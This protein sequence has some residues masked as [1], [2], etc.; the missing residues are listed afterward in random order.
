LRGRPEA[1]Q[2]CAPPGPG[3]PRQQ[4]V[5][6]ASDGPLR[7]G[8]RAAPDARFAVTMRIPSAPRFAGYT[9]DLPHRAPTARISSHE[10]VT[11]SVPLSRRH[12]LG[13][14]GAAGGSAA[15]YR[16]ALVLG[17]A[18]MVA[19]AAQPDIAPLRPG[20]RRKVVILGAGIS[21]LTAA[22]ELSRKGYAVTVLEA[23]HRAGGRNLTLRHGDLIDEL[24]DPRHCEFD[25][26]PDLYFNAGPARIP[27][28]HTALLGYC[29]AFGVSLS[30]LINLNH[31][32]WIQDDAMFGGQRVR[33]REYMTS[34]RGF[35]SELAAKCIKPEDLAAPLTHEDYERLRE[36]L[37]HYGD[38]DKQFQYHGSARAGL[39][40]YDYTQP[41]TL[42]QPLDVH[43]MLQTRLYEALNFDENLDQ[44]AMM[45]EPV[46]GMDRVIDGFMRQVG[47]LVHL[48]APVESVQLTAQGVKVAYR[49]GGQVSVIDAD[50]CLNC[51]PA[52]IMASI[53][54]NLPK[55]YAEGLASLPAGHLFKVGFQA[56]ERFWE[57][58]GI[59][60]GISW[61][62]QDI[63]QLWY[64]AH[65]IHARKG[66]LLGAYMWDE[67]AGT[68]FTQMTHA[69]RIETA[70]VQGEKL[71]PGYRGYLEHGVSIAWKN[72]NHLMGC[73]AIW[74]E[75]LRARYFKL[76]QEP[77]GNHYMI[78]DQISYEAGWQEGAIHSAYHAIADIDRRVRATA[79][80]AAA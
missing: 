3:A 62:A 16:M 10:D 7:D 55:E 6:A 36:F 52:Q 21:G 40:S 79:G 47:K 54:N 9:A 56:K 37:R 58:E 15:A 14:A 39:A 5:R 61:T 77:A 2:A 29:R 78:G 17:I 44:A 24:G 45:V 72:M 48:H 63:T 33:N 71:H 30:P 25:A 50:Y 28:H 43:Q 31:N 4:S 38:L 65:G 49:R 80:A 46:G 22:Y 51:I 11:M 69:Q 1:V 59:Y 64:P 26:D 27:G 12:F 34:V 73:A 41:E 19:H 32:G 23:S 13:L 66:I 8:F 20:T 60:G 57:R 67:T 74:D 68:K 42:K 76:L 18:P 70:I 35:I 53:D 75:A